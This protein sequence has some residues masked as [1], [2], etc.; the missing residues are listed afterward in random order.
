VA[1]AFQAAREADPSAL[2]IFND[3][4]NHT[5][6]GWTTP[7]T[8][9]IVRHLKELGL[10][11]GVGL[12]MH[13]DGSTPPTKEAVITTMRSYGVP[14][15]VTEFDVNMTH[16][17]GAQTDRDMLEACLES[18]VCR[19]FTVWGIGDKYSWLEAYQSLP[20]ADATMYDDRLQPKPAYFAVYNVLL[21]YVTAQP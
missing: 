16:V 5:L 21:R 12:E 19:S 18:G 20:N 1:T 2:L 13:L 8:W 10:V 3:T 14:V 9:R 4:D 6:D 15:V 7:Q 11:D 17:G